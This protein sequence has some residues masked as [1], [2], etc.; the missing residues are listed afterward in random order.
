M[1]VAYAAAGAPPPVPDGAT[2][3][4]SPMTAGLAPDR[5]HLEVSWDV[6]S[7]PAD[8]YNL[9]FGDLAQVETVTITSAECG[10]G[11]G[12]TAT[13]LPPAGDVF[14]LLAAENGAGVESGHGVDSEGSPR[15][16]TG[17]GFCGIGEQSLEGTC[18]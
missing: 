17:V 14:F 15:P 10:L 16:S 2:V 13:V 5:L 12:G 1:F 7:C 3:P 8:D 4:G 11:A 9:F 18:P 6:T